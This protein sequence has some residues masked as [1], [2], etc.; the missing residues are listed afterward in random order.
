MDLRG[1]F[2]SVSLPSSP[3]TG[4]AAYGN[5]LKYIQEQLLLHFDLNSHI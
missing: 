1:L 3:Q 5:I 2:T 4:K